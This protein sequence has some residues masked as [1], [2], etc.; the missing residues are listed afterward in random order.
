MEG[1]MLREIVGLI[2]FVL[3]FML[4]YGG[5]ISIEHNRETWK[6]IKEFIIKLYRVIMGLLLFI[7]V[8]IILCVISYIPYKIFISIFF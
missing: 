8:F 4:V 7:M 1:N 2:C 6:Q 3:F 5:I